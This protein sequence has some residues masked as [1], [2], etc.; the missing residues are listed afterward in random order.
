MLGSYP[1]SMGNDTDKRL[2]EWLRE[3]GCENACD[4]LVDAG[5]DSLVMMSSLDEEEMQMLEICLKDLPLVKQRR[6]MKKAEELAGSDFGRAD[7]ISNEFDVVSVPSLPGAR[8]PAVHTEYAAA[9]R[10]LAEKDA[11]T[12]TANSEHSGLPH[13]QLMMSIVPMT[14]NVDDLDDTDE[15]DDTDGVGFAHEKTL[16]K[17][18][19]ISEA[20]TAASS[21]V[22]SRVNNFVTNP[23]EQG[24]DTTPKVPPPG[25]I[26]EVHPVQMIMLVGGFLCMNSGWVNGVGFRGF[27][28]GVNHVTGTVTKIG[29]KLAMGKLEYSLRATAK[30]LVFMLG[31]MISGS[32]LGR[33]RLFKGGPRYAHLIL[34]ASAGI[35]A[36]FVAEKQEQ[37]LM[38]G[39]LLTFS[40]GVQNACTTIYT[41]A[42][43]KTAT[44]TST[45]S[46]IGIEIGMI[47][48]QNDRR[49][50]WKLKVSS[51]FLLS[52][53]AG[54]FLGGLCFDP[55]AISGPD[56]VG[57]E[58]EALIVPA[59]VLLAIG[60]AWLV[61]LRFS[62][63]DPRGYGL[64]AEVHWRRPAAPATEGVVLKRRNTLFAIAAAA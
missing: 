24:T 46:D 25:R 20:T 49:G 64:L 39:L 52:Y 11:N 26:D 48:F 59:S 47:L 63:P 7:P 35:F 30:V 62:E 41:G 58:A 43:L 3:F 27:D 40:S 60:T 29:L 16:S 18:V 38:G 53:I 31:A 14:G 44:V 2:R 19:S 34:L 13:P 21:R 10:I 42:V 32:Y 15:S 56:F 12:R 37:N 23:Q 61:S 50:C 57:S 1:R 51:V 17:T 22:P 4:L 28:E 8:P 6:I 55:T 54:G 33:S 45:A 36:A 9:A 5:F